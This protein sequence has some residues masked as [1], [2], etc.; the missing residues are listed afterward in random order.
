MFG[1]QIKVR[2]KQF[3]TDEFVNSVHSLIPGIRKSKDCLGCSFYKNDE[4]D[5]AW[6]LIGEWQT[7]KAMDAHFLSRNFKVMV[8]A[9]QV[10]GETFEMHLFKRIGSGGIEMARAMYCSSE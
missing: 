10:L 4:I 7:H 1:Y 8:G 5:N 9:A 6:T 2:T 3:K